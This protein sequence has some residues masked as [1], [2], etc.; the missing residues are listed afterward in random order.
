MYADDTIIALA[1]PA[2]TAALA[3]LRIS[4]KEAHRL[5]TALIR[6][7][8]R[9][10]TSEA[11]RL[12]LYTIHDGTGGVIDEVTAVKYNA[13]VSFTGEDMVEIICHG[14][15]V[16]VERIISRAV[17]CGGRYA[18][19]GEFSRRAF[20]N[21]KIDLKKAES[22]DRIIHAQS[23]VNHRN[24]VGHYLGRE[25]S[26]FDGLKGDIR[27]LI[28]D[29]ETEIEFSDTD[30]V[31]TEEAFAASFGRLTE[32]IRA[33]FAG[34]LKKRE[35]L[36]EI[37]RGVAVCIAGRAN[38]GK[39]SLLN[40]LLGYDRAIINTQKGTTRDLI[41]E[42]MRLGDV[43][44][45]F[46][47]TAGLNDTPADD[48]EREGIMRTRAALSESALVLWVLSADTDL[49]PEDYQTVSGAEQVIAV[50]NKTD[51]PGA[52][53]VEAF[54]EDISLQGHHVSTASQEGIAGLIET[55]RA[56]VEAS[57]STDEYE[58]VIG[59]EREESLIRRILADIETLDP[60]LPLELQSEVLRD[61]LSYLDDIYGKSSPEDI[62][63]DVF[64]RFCIG[65]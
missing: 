47:D 48:I 60:A 5:F 44:I 62:I 38:A 43:P 34:E 19:R 24:A 51:L 35:V 14:G 63:N 45:R 58:T 39:S 49:V 50:I 30:D 29:M 20:L 36:K 55:V 23:V 11:F 10:H 22:I 7:E 4:G 1:T 61:V 28:A 2:G 53:R 13:P 18:G 15:R 9:F 57:F 31:E 56:V 37:D 40:A 65:K 46:I 32:K 33:S 6:E 64:D 16:V 3:V 25:R 52:H 8:G 59:S 17:A 12:H 42:S 21:G 26:F 54:L 27:T 41:S